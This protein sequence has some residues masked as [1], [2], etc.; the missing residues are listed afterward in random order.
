MTRRFWIPVL[1]WA[2]FALISGYG[3]AVPYTEPGKYLGPA[4][5]APTP[6]NVRGAISLAIWTITLVVTIKYEVLVM[7]AENDGE[8]GVFDLYGLL[9]KA[10]FSLSDK[11]FS[12]SDTFSNRTNS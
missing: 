4:A 3:H 12:G 7:R 10:S 6:D 2:M 1:A 11:T 5:V 9:H 8:G